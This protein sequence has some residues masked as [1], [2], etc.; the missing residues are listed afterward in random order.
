LVL[1]GDAAALQAAVRDDTAAV[2]LEPG[3]ARAV[4]SRPGPVT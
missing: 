1:F 4:W 2:F 3:W